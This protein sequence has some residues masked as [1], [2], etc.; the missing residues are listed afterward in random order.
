MKHYRP[1][2]CANASTVAAMPR[3][4]RLDTVI[5]VRTAATAKA[6]R[7]WLD[8]QQWLPEIGL[9]REAWDLHA[10]Y[11]PE[12]AFDLEAEATR[13]NEVMDTVGNV[14]IFLS[15][16]A[17]LETI[18]AQ[19]EASGADVPRDPF[20]H[21]RLNDVNPGAWFAEQFGHR[22]PDDLPR[23]NVKP[24]SIHCIGKLAA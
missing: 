12:A 15:E 2:A 9:S 5:A 20:G 8:T 21:V 24:V 6:Y 7:A 22:H 13:L 18:V 23:I 11:V 16:G 19:L 3:Q 10:V 1:Q 4:T 14:T 17:G